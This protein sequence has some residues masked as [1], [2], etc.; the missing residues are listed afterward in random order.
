MKKHEPAVKLIN[1]D[2][3]SALAQMDY[4]VNQVKRLEDMKAWDLEHGLKFPKSYQRDLEK[5]QP[6]IEPLRLKV[7]SLEASREALWL[8][9]GKDAQQ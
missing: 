2:L 9:A 5:L 4:A 1:A 7:A 3:R 6:T 8:D